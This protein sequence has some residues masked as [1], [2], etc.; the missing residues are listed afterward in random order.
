MP[1]MRKPVQLQWTLH[2]RA[3]MNHYRLTPSRVRHVLHSPKRTEEGVAPKTVAMMQPVSMKLIGR[4]ES[5]T[6]EIWV[7][8]QDAADGRKVISAWRY[9]GVT[10]PRDAAFLKKEY[11]EFLLDETTTIK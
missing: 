3:K 10:K 9:P 5:W 11:G 8:I 6:Q 2:A 4:K 1:F 7:M